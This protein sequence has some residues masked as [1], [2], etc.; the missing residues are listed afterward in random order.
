MRTKRCIIFSKDQIIKFWTR[1]CE[2]RNLLRINYSRLWWL[3]SVCENLGPCLT[4]GPR[5][6]YWVRCLG[7]SRAGFSPHH[8][9]AKKDLSRSPSRVSPH[10]PPHAHCLPSQPLLL[11][12][13]PPLNLLLA[14][15]A[16]AA[17]RLPL[18]RTTCPPAGDCAPPSPPPLLPAPTT[19]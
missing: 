12:P 1:S 15:G 10:F 4:C 3:A 16:D 18:V 19:G 13:F 5:P 6:S 7:E 2:V 14:G 17:Q 8:S 9:P 11:L